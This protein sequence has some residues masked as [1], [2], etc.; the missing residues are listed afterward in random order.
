MFAG[1]SHQERQL[2]GIERFGDVVVGTGLECLD[3]VEHLV[4]MPLH[5][6]AAPLPE[7]PA[8]GVDLPVAGLWTFE[9]VARFGEFDQVIFAVQIPVSG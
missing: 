5:L 2:I 9:V 7:Q 4:D 8:V 3:R 6:D 1:P